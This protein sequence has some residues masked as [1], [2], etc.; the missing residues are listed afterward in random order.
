MKAFLKLKTWLIT[1]GII[2]LGIA[3]SFIIVYVEYSQDIKTIEAG[4]GDNVSGYAWSENFGWVSF[5]CSNDSSCGTV[6]YGVNVDSDTGNF[7]G[8]AWSENAGWIDF[9]PV[10]PYPESPQ[11]SANYNNTTGVVTG[12][13]KVL[14][15][16]EGGWLK[17]S[18]TWSNGVSI[19]S[20]GDFHGWAWNGNADDSGI[21]W[22]SFNCLD[23]DVCGTSNY[24]VHGEINSL[25][26]A[27]NLSAPNWSFS[28]ACSL[29]AR[30]AFLRWEF[31]DADDGSYQTA[32]QIILDDDS[33]IDSPILDTGKV[34]SGAVQYALNADYLDYDTAYY[35]WV[36]VW[37]DNNVASDW[38]QYDSA[39]DTD[40]EDGNDLTF[41]VYKHELPDVNFSWLP[42][43]SSV[44]EEVYFSDTTAVYGG[45][46]IEELLWQIPAD[47]NI[48]DD[49]TSTPVIIFGSSGNQNVNLQVTDSDGYYCDLSQ[50]VDI[51]VSLPSWTET[52]AD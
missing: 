51:N 48:N 11:N 17:M 2:V 8:Y 32:Y 23:T 24:A 47:A 50:T 38:A 52:K 20:S 46:S 15:L 37:D 5:N 25:P 13:A 10:G 26:E 12:W 43:S 16:D 45:S 18:G 6:D 1:F 42:T 35:W 3:L 27:V 31:S 14:S 34:D 9:A 19:D 21:G 29:S 49:A 22:L 44:G 33:D 40:N 41:T 36:K 30:Q 28:Q 39:T 7:S 4:S